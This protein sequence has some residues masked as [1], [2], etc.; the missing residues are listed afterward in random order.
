MNVNTNEYELTHGKAP[1]GTGYWAFLFYRMG[2][3]LI[4]IEFAP[5]SQT[6]GAAR[7]WAVAKAKE[8]GADRVAVAT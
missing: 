7:K 1:R 4:V 5:G 2:M 3:G 6:Y 8:L